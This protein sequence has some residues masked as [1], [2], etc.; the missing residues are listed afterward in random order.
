MSFVVPPIGRTVDAVLFDWQLTHPQLQ[1]SMAVLCH[2]IEAACTAGIHVAVVGGEDLAGVDAVL[3]ARPSGGGRL[4]L[5]PD[6]RTLVEITAGGPQ[7][8]DCA[9]GSVHGVLDRLADRGITGGLVL[10]AGLDPAWLR[11]RMLNAA[12]EPADLVS[13]FDEQ[14][15]RRGTR[16]VPSVDEDPDWTVRETGGD[17]LRHRITETLFTL[18]AQGFA[19]RGSVEEP[20]PAST[21][22]M[23]ASGVYRGQGQD[24][25][26]L[27][28][29][30]WTGLVIDPPPAEDERV[31]DLRTGVLIREEVPTGPT[32]LRTLRFISAT[33]PGVAALRAEGAAGRLRA[34]P[35]F[36]DAGADAV[37]GC[38]GMRSW[39]RVGDAR[40]AGIG[41]V[42]AQRSSRDR[43]AKDE[44][45]TTVERVAAY[46]ADEHRPPALGGAEALLDSLADIGFDTLLAE[47]RAA[48]AARWRSVDV[49]IPDDPATQLAVRY[50]LFQL[51]CNVNRHDELAVGA[52]GL[53]GT[54]YSGH[55]F[56][57]ADAFVLPAMVSI[58]PS[59]ARAMVRYR[60]ERLGAAQRHA[61]SSGHLGARY[62][63]ESAASGD[64]VTPSAGDLGGTWVP[65]LT[66]QREEHVTADIAWASMHDMEWAGR[67]A[68]VD[69][70]VTTLLLETARY[71]ASRCTRDADG[72]A[73][74]RRVIG[75]DEYHDCV[76]DNA[77]T[78]VMAR[79][80]LRAAADAAAQA[81]VADD[82]AAQWLAL[83]DRL[84]DGYDPVSGRYEQF[85]GYFDLEPLLMADVAA[86]PVA[87]DLLLGRER[88]AASQVIKQPDVLML[89]HLVPDEVRRGSLLPNLDY[90]GPRTAH[91]SSLSPAVSAALLA[92]AGRPD[93]GLR[94]LRHALTLD[95]GD[96]T[97]MTAAGLHL[98]NLGGVWQAMVGGFAGVRARCGELLIEPRLP[99]SWSSLGLRFRALGCRIE[100]SLDARQVRIRSDAPLRVRLA[101]Q[102]GCTVHTSL[103]LDRLDDDTG[104]TR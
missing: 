79:W 50:A 47:H 91:G 10:G 23:L 103:T 76:D 87:A 62:P 14:L 31:L 44:P 29:P 84:V 17:P 65:I 93:E 89:H 97:G 68:A 41:A 2:R 99:S 51:W 33:L 49:T 64:D 94:M 8:L 100:L 25:R 3:R 21:P 52:R 22:L 60:L 53:S 75:P 30:D 13:V 42:A 35:A 71:W 83:A 69:R 101:G 34:G 92:R 56:W 102:D 96:T 67:A 5:C 82:E 18:G 11:P 4:W 59:A 26:L 73:H 15:R 81:G 88:V 12:V 61:R 74:I 16:R 48:W 104:A 80:N 1:R 7:L 9:D 46:V 55:V 43:Q 32:A 19:S 77:F 20:D 85:A 37:T 54:G 95:L 38:V 28:G 63:W 70:E 45:R 66:G 57:D 36:R 98:A 40:G 72:S 58:E 6:A 24:E 90:Y 39:A 86:P 27:A 78:N